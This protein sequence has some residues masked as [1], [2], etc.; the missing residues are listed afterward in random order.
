MKLQPVIDEVLILGLDDCV[1]AF[2]VASFS[3][4]E[5]GAKGIDELRELSM[6]CLRTLLADCLMQIGSVTADRGFVPWSLPT[7]DALTRVEKE[8]R[9]L[10]RGP[11][12]GDIFWLNLTPK[13]KVAATKI[14]T[15]RLS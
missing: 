2:Q 3:Q 4:T 14:L 6:R 12:L 15:K 13:G 10:P 5:G 11:T 7:E 9:L 1:Q 8:W